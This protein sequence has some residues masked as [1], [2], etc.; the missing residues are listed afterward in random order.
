[1]KQVSE[2]YKAENPDSPALLARIT[3]N[4][5]MRERTPPDSCALGVSRVVADSPDSGT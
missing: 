1:M 2:T 4:L 5:R 3:T